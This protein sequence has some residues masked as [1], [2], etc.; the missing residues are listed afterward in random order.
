[1]TNH[2]H[3]KVGDDPWCDWLG[4]QAG[5][6]INTAVG[7]D[8]LCGHWTAASAKATASLLRPH[9]KRGRVKV[10]AGRCPNDGRG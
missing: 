1:M 3:I 4:S 7:K 2:H 10:V 8:C 6:R 9:F 5:Q